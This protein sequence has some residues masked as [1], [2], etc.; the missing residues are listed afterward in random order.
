MLLHWV[1]LALV[2]HSFRLPTTALHRDRLNV[3]KNAI[4]FP[5]RHSYFHGFPLFNI[6]LWLS[7]AATVG[8]KL[9]DN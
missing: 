2:I 7:S 6:Q 9:Q 1:S 5:F 4:K 3:V 8:I